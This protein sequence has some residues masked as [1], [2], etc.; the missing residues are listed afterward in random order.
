MEPKHARSSSKGCSK[1][2]DTL[3]LYTRGQSYHLINVSQ[4]CRKPAATTISP[5]VAISPVSVQKQKHGLH[6]TSQK[7]PPWVIKALITLHIFMDTIK[8]K[9]T[10]KKIADCGLKS[11]KDPISSWST[12]WTLWQADCFPAP[13]FGACEKWG[14]MQV[15][16]PRWLINLPLSPRWC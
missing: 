3:L 9:A 15:C 11:P 10:I 7:N 16:G 1:N 2:T 14:C 8:N 6:I 12:W 4:C 13:I 5:L